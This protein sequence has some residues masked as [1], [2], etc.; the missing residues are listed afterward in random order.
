MKGIGVSA[1]RKREK[2]MLIESS[3]SAAFKR[4]TRILTA[5]KIVQNDVTRNLLTIQIV[6]VRSDFEWLDTY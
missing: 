5:A 4:N 1:S 2:D 6:T 3:I